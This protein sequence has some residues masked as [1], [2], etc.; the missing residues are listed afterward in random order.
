M[1]SHNRY[2]CIHGHFYQPP[3]ENPWL[4]EVELQDSAYPYHDWNERITAEC[5]APNTASRILGS[6]GKIIDIVNNYARINFN[7]G[8]TLLSWLERHQP[9]VY[10][11][12]LEADKVSIKRF[13]GHG[14]AMAQVY[15][16]MIMPLAGKRDKTTQ[17][18]WGI[19]DFVKRFGR[20]PEGL[21]LPETAV[22]LETLEILADSGIRFTVLAPH[23]IRRVKK[24]SGG[25]WQEVEGGRIDPTMAYLCPLP[26]GKAI[27]IFV[28]DGPI[29]QDIAFGGLLNNGEAFA[30][31]L[32]GAFHKDR[33][34]PQVVHIATDGETYGHHHRYGDMALSYCLY[35]I[36]SEK[37]TG[38][39]NYGE[40]LEKHPPTHIIEIT[41][42]TSWSCVHGVERWR[43]NCGCHSGTHPEWT[44]TWRKPLRDA[45]DW[46]RDRV[47][48]IYEEGAEGYLRDPWLARDEYIEVISNRSRN[49]VEEFLRRHEAKVLTRSDMSRMLK[50]L[51]MQRHAMLMYTS[52]GWFFDDIS[53]IE[54]VQVMQYAARVIQLAEEAQGVSLESNYMKILQ[55]A[56]S[57]RHENGAVIYE[58]FVK[59]ARVDLQRA[60]AHHAIMS[61]FDS[62]PDCVKIY[63]YTIYNEG[64]KRLTAGKL[65]LVIGKSRVTSDITWDEEVIDFAVL[66]LGDHNINGGVSLFQG[67][68]IFSAMQNEIRPVF[69]KGDIPEVIRLLNKHFG[70]HNYSVSDLF[71]DEQRK[72][73]NQI[74]RFTYKEIATAFGQI[75][76]NHYTLMNFFQ[77]LQIPIP[78]PLL[79][80]TD[81]V[82]NADLQETLQQK[83][84]DLA[85]LEKLVREAKRWSVRLDTATIGFLASVQ[86]EALLK[87]SALLPEGLA[88]M[89]S[90]NKIL[91]NLAPLHI[92]LNL[93]KSQNLYFSIGKR[94]YIHMNEQAK[95]GSASAKQWVETF[96]RLGQYLHVKVSE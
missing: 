35:S 82:T 43:E 60:G 71:K 16:H 66:H 57:N 77:S 79:L 80:A 55:E 74:L 47:S 11:A 54:T 5:Y 86:I 10:Q 76:E 14:S 31:R 52:C 17:V 58:K 90:V 72:V 45:M 13:S 22:D 91:E 15:N 68:E 20:S 48:A 1:D 85:R 42:K 33:D 70:E 39:T 9:D 34:W 65:K 2:I 3:R 4:E 83:E 67:D 75:Q 44:Q 81:F 18:L 12:I 61:L 88:L 96:L 49:H 53:G 56:P 89:E 50:F 26:S 93:W 69:E 73:L 19:R 94:F 64:H 21:W 78:R 46:L 25:E 62:C 95:Q 8:P 41:E 24:I 29:S 32:L 63:C 23:Q 40:Y 38:L 6:D 30:R 37:T 27:H 51:E 28:Y 87:R 36:E 7:F 92:E 84:A 59:P